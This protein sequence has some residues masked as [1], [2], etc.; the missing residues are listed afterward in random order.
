MVKLERTD[1]GNFVKCLAQISAR[2]GKIATAEQAM[3]ERIRQGAGADICTRGFWLPENWNSIQ[4]D[5]LVGLQNYNPIISY[6]RRAVNAH[7]KGEEFYLSNKVLLGGKPATQVLREIAEADA[8]KPVYKRRVLISKNKEQ[9]TD[10]PTKRLGE[11][12]EI[13]FLARG[14]KLAKDY[15]E[16]LYDFGIEKTL[17]YRPSLLEGKDLARGFWLFGLVADD[18]SVFVGNHRYLGYEVGSLLGVYEK[19]AE[20]TSQ[21][22]LPYTTK[23]L[24]LA[25]KELRSLS[26]ILQPQQLKHTKSLVAKLRQ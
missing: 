10:V 24:K 7:K 6:A 3:Q 12:E 21:K 18:R 17:I 9:K 8:K 19:S 11:E 16:F 15:G 13:I 14:E 5:I 20:G 23:N 4:G 26:K 2:E 25:E 1:L 22:I